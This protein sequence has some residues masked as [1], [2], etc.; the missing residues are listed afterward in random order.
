M[1]VFVNLNIYT[2]SELIQSVYIM[3]KI[4][5]YAIYIYTLGFIMHTIR[6]RTYDLFIFISNFN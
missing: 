1:R 6:A 4:N 2:Y 3:K 5:H